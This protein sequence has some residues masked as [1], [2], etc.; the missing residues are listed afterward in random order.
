[1]SRCIV[2]LRPAH[3]HASISSGITQVSGDTAIHPWCAVLEV[4]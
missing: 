2:R 4:Q 1:M 3:T